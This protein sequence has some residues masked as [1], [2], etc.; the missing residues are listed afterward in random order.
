MSRLIS[1]ITSADA[2][3]RNQSFESVCEHL[4][5]NE[6]LNESEALEKFRK[7]TENL[8]EKVRVLFFLYAIHRFFFPLQKEISKRSLIPYDSYRY[9]LKRRFE[10]AI[11][12]LLEI[13]RK[14]DPTK[15]YP[16]H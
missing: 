2:E 7:E 3:V 10:E 16:V 9:L 6:L 8:Y 12:I 15:G 1:I 5:L 13:Q 14:K 4:S 11:E